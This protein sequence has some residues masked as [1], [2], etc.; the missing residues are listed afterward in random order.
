MF[1]MTPAVLVKDRFL[2]MKHRSSINAFCNNYLLIYCQHDVVLHH[3][4]LAVIQ[5]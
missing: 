4:S 3:I 5:F 1:H 2:Y